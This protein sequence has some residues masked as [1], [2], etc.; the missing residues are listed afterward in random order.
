M[1]LDLVDGGD[2]AGGLDDGVDVLDGEVGDT[3]VLDL[4][5]GQGDDGLPGVDERDAIIELDLVGLVGGQ[6]EEVAAHVADEGEGD[7]P[8][9]Q[10]E[11][12]VVE[13]QLGEGV[14]EGLLDVLGAVRIVPQLGGD[15]DVL[16]LEAEFLQAL[17]QALGD[18]L[19][20]LVDLGQVE[21]AVASLEGL[22][23]AN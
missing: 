23:D 13:L 16:A 8:V 7:G 4:G 10:E 18:L 20:V 6:G 17:V 14:V 11:V 9:D 21:V 3:N 19:L 22:V 1:S 12:E 15:E 5:L 2:D